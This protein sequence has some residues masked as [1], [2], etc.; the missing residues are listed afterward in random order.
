MMGFKD[1]N[2][3]KNC[4]HKEGDKCRAYPVCAEV[5]IKVKCPFNNNE[6]CTVDTLFIENFSDGTEE[7]LNDRETNI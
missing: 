5:H 3:Y 4:I 2:V 6:Q 1:I 7:E